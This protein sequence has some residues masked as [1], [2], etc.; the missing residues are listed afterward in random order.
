[1]FAVEVCAARSAKTAPLRWQSFSPL[2]TEKGRES[3]RA[4]SLLNLST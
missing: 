3:L 2:C 1:M 4:P